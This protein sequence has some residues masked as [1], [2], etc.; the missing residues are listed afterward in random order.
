MEFLRQLTYENDRWTK[1]M[2]NFEEVAGEFD[3]D[4]DD[5]ESFSISS[6]QSN[7]LSQQ[8]NVDKIVMSSQPHTSKASLQIS[9]DEISSIEIMSQPIA[10]N[11][12]IQTSD[13]D[14]AQTKSKMRRVRLKRKQL[15]CC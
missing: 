13:E 6:S 12:A 15:D 11:T 3:S 9:N 4:S 1:R 10:S 8:S 2:E 14:N 7:P 5:D